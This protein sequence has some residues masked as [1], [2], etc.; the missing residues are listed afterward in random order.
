VT[1]NQ[2]TT[3][4]QRAEREPCRIRIRMRSA[5]TWPNPGELRAP[6]TSALLPA[7]G[8]DLIEFKAGWRGDENRFPADSHQNIT[9]SRMKQIFCVN[10]E[11]IIC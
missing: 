7:D 2:A 11:V 8:S 3:P 4:V 5:Q 10:G 6:D 9:G 1:V